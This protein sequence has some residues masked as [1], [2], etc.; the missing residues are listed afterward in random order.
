[1]W[2]IIAKKLYYIDIKAPFVLDV[3]CFLVKYFTYFSVFGCVRNEENIL[4]V[5]QFSLIG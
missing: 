3:N 1:M 4:H 2:S 5:K